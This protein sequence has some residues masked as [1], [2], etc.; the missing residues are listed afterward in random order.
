LNIMDMRTVLFSYV[1]SNG[2]CT[3]VMVFLLLQNRKRSPGLGFWL[4][5]YCMQF[6]TVV[7]I[8]F[9]GSL[10][11]FFT[12]VV[13]NAL[14]VGGTILLLIGLERYIGKQGHQLHNVIL[15]AFFVLVHS[16]FTF[17]EPNLLARNIN[18]SAGLLIICAQCAWLM[19][20]RVSGNLRRETF[21]TG[22]VFGIYTLVNAVRI[23]MDLVFHPGEDFFRSGLSDTI[24]IA[25]Y[26][27]LFI[28]LTF[29]LFLLVN[30]RLYSALERDIHE[31]EKAEA[32]REAA[33]RSLS[34]SEA[35]YRNLVEESHDL[36]FTHDLALNIFA[37][38]PALEK[39]LDIN[40]DS[41]DHPNLYAF[42]SAQKEEQFT[43]YLQTLNEDGIARG[44]WTIL[45]GQD[46]ERI[47]EYESTLIENRSQRI[48]ARCMAQDIT[49]KVQREQ[50]LEAIASISSAIRS[51]V[52]GQ[53]ILPTI[54]QELDRI[55]GADGLAISI[56][57]E[58]NGKPRINLCSGEWQSWAGAAVSLENGISGQV[59]ETNQLVIDK[60]SSQRSTAECPGPLG[61]IQ[62]VICAPLI[63]NQVLI[64]VLWLGRE[65]TFSARKIHLIRTV[66]DICASAIWNVTLYRQVEDRVTTL[67]SL[68]DAGLALNNVIDLNEKFVFFL[69][70]VMDE[71]HVERIA[72]LRFYPGKSEFK[73]EQTRGFSEGLQ[74]AIGQSVFPVGREDSPVGWVYANEMPLNYPDTLGDVALCLGDPAVRSVLWAPVKHG[75]HFHGILCIMR[76]TANAFG[77]NQER[78]LIQFAN[79]AAGAL[80]YDR[81]LAEKNH[82]VT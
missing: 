4:A 14:A 54:M 16:F 5:D 18:V 9:R 47:L 69:K 53:D 22:I 33:L 40:V 73:V 44:R 61:E 11:D 21:L 82:F 57:E 71:F 43:A 3:V 79:Q 75:D 63:A 66:S 59:Y 42:T 78:L 50:E 15:L 56:L 19:L 13:A 60:D 46:D 48:L 34:N 80:E 72:F 12:V 8:I 41:P 81:L 49:E 67:V 38:N 58:E 17:V 31:R 6:C 52:P 28:A 55:I 27:M 77:P 26:Q 1:I 64:G 39:L 25:A 23:I 7:L 45:V 32:Q 68:Y 37:P 62:T 24:A 36:I 30:R 2:L 20:F 65:K 74:A 70:I 35:R 10:P 29:A 51:L 76:T